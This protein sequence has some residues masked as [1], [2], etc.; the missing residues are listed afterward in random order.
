MDPIKL[1][2]NLPDWIS[3]PVAI[4]MVALHLGSHLKPVF[5]NMGVQS[6]TV[7]RK[8]EELELLKIQ[9]E[10]TEI[11]QKLGMPVAEQ[12]KDLMAKIEL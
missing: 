7:K 3:I 10:L 2:P 9:F 8:R 5:Q 12:A 4:T 6:Q 11:K 1:L